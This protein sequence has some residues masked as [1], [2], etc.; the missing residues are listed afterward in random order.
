ML[1]PFSG[2]LQARSLE[3][4][5]KALQPILRDISDSSILNGNLVAVVFPSSAN[6]DVTIEH[7]LSRTPTGYIPVAI[8]AAGI[9]YSSPTSQAQPDLQLTLRSNTASLT[10]TVWVF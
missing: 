2:I 5:Q 8:S 1:K 7:G 10:A 9:I 6:T 3:Q 4:L